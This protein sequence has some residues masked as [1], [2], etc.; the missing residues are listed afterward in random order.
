[1]MTT[2]TEEIVEQFAAVLIRV[3]P[4]VDIWLQAG[5]NVTIIEFSV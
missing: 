1:M 2:L 5:I 3:K 4:V